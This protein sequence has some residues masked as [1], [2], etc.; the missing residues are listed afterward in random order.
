M[1]ELKTNISSWESKTFL[2][3]ECYAYFSPKQNKT[4]F[5]KPCG[6][7]SDRL[8]PLPL[9]VWIAHRTRR[10]LFI[11]WNRPMG[12]E[13]FLE[14]ASVLDW[15]MPRELVPHLVGG[16][17]GGTLIKNER[18][19]YAMA[20][21]GPRVVRSRL[22][23]PGEETFRKKTKLSY[24]DVFPDLWTALFRPVPRLQTK[25]DAQ[26]AA[27]GLTPDQYAATHIRARH[28]KHFSSAEVIQA[29]NRALRCTSQLFPGAPILVASD[30]SD[31]YEVARNVSL[32]YLNYSFRVETL[33][34][35]SFIHLDWDPQWETRTADDYDGVFQDLYLLGSA[36]CVSHGVGGYG[37]FGMRM[38][39]GASTCGFDHAKLPRI[40]CAFNFSSNT[41][42]TNN[43]TTTSS[44]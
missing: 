10:I 15:R 37:K 35:N 29:T 24:E 6:G 5:S 30:L 25:I 28:N 31:V 8:T 26:L 12:L 32:E 42:G 1:Q 21:T 9:L 27:H 39:V 2:I 36:K 20:M 44:P 34:E 16:G 4:V 23:M 3:M 11:Y 7:L 43:G 13:E 14:P 19:A 18:N 40:P 33:D 17:G 38:T 41:N 22:Q